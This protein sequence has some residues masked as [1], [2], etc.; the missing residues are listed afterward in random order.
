MRVRFLLPHKFMFVGL[1][2]VVLGVISAYTR[3]YLGIKPSFL[4]IPVFTIYSSFIDTKT[5]QIIT[6]NISEEIVI[7]LL[8]IGLLLINFSK[9]KFEDDIVD[10][11]R[12]K[13]LL[14]SVLIN[15]ILLLLSTVF[16]YGLAFISILSINIFSQLFIYQIFFRIFII[17]NKRN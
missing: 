1:L 5:F 3:F 2:L 13:A 9:E 10:H 15:S 17:V 8:L 6:N 14:Y 12:F 16:I 4:T 7:L 11:F